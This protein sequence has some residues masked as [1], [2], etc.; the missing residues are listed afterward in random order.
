MRVLSDL[1]VRVCIFFK[2]LTFTQ[3][4]PPVPVKLAYTINSPYGNRYIIRC[5]RPPNSQC[6][7]TIVRSCKCNH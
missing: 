5:L 2:M 3:V 4:L 1:K 6:K 7:F